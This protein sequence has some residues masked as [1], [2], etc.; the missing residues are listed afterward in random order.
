MFPSTVNTISRDMMD[1]RRKT[2]MAESKNLSGFVAR[3]I[4]L[5]SQG[6]H[7]ETCGGRPSPGLQY[8]TRR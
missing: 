6:I 8:S 1:G 2:Y 7:D 5:P 3:C 4:P